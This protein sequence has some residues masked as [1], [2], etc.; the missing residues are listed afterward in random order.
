ML[1]LFGMWLANK[2]LAIE[3]VVSRDPGGQN[4]LITDLLLEN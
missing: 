4:P 3:A 1:M 2:E